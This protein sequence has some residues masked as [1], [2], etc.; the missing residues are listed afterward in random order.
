MRVVVCVATVIV[1]M[2]TPSFAQTQ[3]G[4][5]EG[6]AGFASSPDTT[7]G[8]VLGEVGVRVAPHLL[9]FGD[10]GQ[11]HNLQPSTVQPSVDLATATLAANQGVTVVG[12]GR[13]PASY[14]IGGLRF[15]IP[16]NSHVTPY[17]LG[18]VGFARLAPTAQFTYS[19]GTLAG[20]TP[21][22]GDD[23]TDQIISMGDF[24]QPAATTAFTF[25][26]GGGVAI[27]VARRWTADV[28]YRFSRVAADTPLNAQGVTFGVGYRF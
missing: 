21:V 6:A 3:R 15:E 10:F 4:Y 18:G 2:A 20:V 9:V 22:A 24:T 12:T 7:S 13:V 8:D 19:S 1:L 26:L 23:V 14:A 27:P 11:F 17:V 16:T 5:V 25:S 28:G